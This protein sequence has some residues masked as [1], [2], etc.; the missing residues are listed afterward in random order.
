LNI[1]Q[2]KLRKS[3]N[4]TFCQYHQKFKTLQKTLKEDELIVWGDFSENLTPLVQNAI[5]SEYFN[6]KQVT[7]HPFTVYYTKEQTVHNLSY[8]VISDTTIHDTNRFYS[9]Q[10]ALIRNLKIKLEELGMP[11]P[12]KIYYFSDGCAGQYKNRKNFI[13]LFHHV[14]DFGISAQ[15]NFFAPAHGKG[16]CDAFGVTT[17]KM[18][19]TRQLRGNEIV[20]SLEIYDWCEENIKNVMYLFVDVNEIEELVA[21]KDLTSRYKGLGT[22]HGGMDF[23]WRRTP[24]NT[25]D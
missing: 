25:I 17:K 6:K 13:N 3:S 23:N 5:Q 24:E 21:R 12:K 7:L 1:S 14:S 22:I 15:W 2:Q 20:T 16:P 11:Q 19:K 18:V 9:F 10:T 4:I 8:R